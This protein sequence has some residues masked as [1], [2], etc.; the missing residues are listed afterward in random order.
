MR[1]LVNFWSSMPIAI[2]INI[3]ILHKIISFFF[4]FITLIVSRRK[5]LMEISL[6][7]KLIW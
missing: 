4:I 3:N 6:N 5:L 1:F 7:K 2:I